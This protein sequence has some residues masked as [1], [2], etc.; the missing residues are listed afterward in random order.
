MNQHWNQIGDGSGWQVAQVFDFVPDTKL[1]CHLGVK[2][3][4]KNKQICL[5]KNLQNL[6]IFYSLRALC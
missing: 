3:K 4:K 6:L 2:G 1:K 5:S